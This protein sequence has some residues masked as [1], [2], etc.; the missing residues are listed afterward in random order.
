MVG[1]L[2]KNIKVV[3]IGE[4]LEWLEQEKEQTIKKL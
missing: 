2:E 4:E 1:V 3:D